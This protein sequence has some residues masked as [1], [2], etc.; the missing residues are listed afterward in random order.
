MK[1]LSP[2]HF[3]NSQQSGTVSSKGNLKRKPN[4]QVTF[5]TCVHLD[6]FL[7]CCLLCVKSNSTITNN[8]CVYLVKC[9][10]N[11]V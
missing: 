10:T 5:F 11:F 3:K 2:K 9:T 1:S 7:V 8:K 4:T 6:R